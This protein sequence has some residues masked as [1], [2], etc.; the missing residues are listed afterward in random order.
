LQPDCFEQPVLEFDPVARSCA[1]SSRE[2]GLAKESSRQ[3]LALLIHQQLFTFTRFP[4]SQWKSIH[5]SNPKSSSDGSRRRPYCLPQ[6][7]QSKPASRDL[8]RQPDSQNGL[9]FEQGQAPGTPAG[10]IAQLL[11]SSLHGRS[12]AGF[13]AN[14]CAGPCRCSTSA[15]RRGTRPISA[16]CSWRVRVCRNRAPSWRQAPDRR[17]R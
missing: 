9:V 15:N 6:K 8:H 5:T 10:R 11:R 13:G 3:L 7:D 1:R 17:A 2:G 14:P 4:I 16:L 12:E